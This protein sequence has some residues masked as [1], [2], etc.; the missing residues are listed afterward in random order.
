M[1]AFCVRGRRWWRR[2][3]RRRASRRAPLLEGIGVGLGGL[4]GGHGR[5]DGGGPRLSLEDLEAGVAVQL[6]GKAAALTPWSNRSAQW[7]SVV[8]PAR[9]QQSPADRP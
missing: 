8:S 6:G 9:A 5:L 7:P 1:M 2:A 4:V 3:L